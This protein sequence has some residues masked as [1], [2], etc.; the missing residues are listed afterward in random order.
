MSSWY[1]VAKMRRAQTLRLAAPCILHFSYHLDALLCLQDCKTG[2][3]RYC[4]FT[5]RLLIAIFLSFTLHPRLNIP[6][7]SC[8]RTNFSSLVPHPPFF[9]FGSLF[10]GS[11]S[12]FCLLF[13][14]FAPSRATSF[15]ISRR[16][17]Q[18]QQNT[19]NDGIHEVNHLTHIL[20]K[21]LLPNSALRW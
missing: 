19:T 10:L 13:P 9:V 3:S 6:S 15:D 4:V 14:A 2:N 8:T 7:P 16:V 17:L 12:R 5:C 18:H 20:S 1:L 21:T 11:Q